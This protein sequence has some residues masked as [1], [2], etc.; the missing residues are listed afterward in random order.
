MEFN[1]IVHNYKDRILNVCYRFVLNKEDAEDLTQEVFIEI[2]KSFG[3][4]KGDSGIYT[5][6]YR[7]AVN[8][9][10]DFLRKNKRQK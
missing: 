2:Y 7:I 9:S 10:L 6:I 8:K 4:F 3:S 1:Q 5:W